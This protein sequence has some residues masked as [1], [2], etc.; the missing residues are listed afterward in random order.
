VVGG[1]HG[2][3]R[4]DD[5]GQLWRPR[6][7]AF[8]DGSHG[9][10]R[11][12]GGAVG[13]HR[14][15]A[16]RAHRGHESD[17]AA[18]RG[19]WHP[20]TAPQTFEW[21]PGSSHTL[22]VVSPQAGAA[23]TR[24]V[25]ASW[26]DG[27]AQSHT[28]TAGASPATYTASFTTQY[29]LTAVAE[30][31][32]GGTVS[33]AGE[34]WH[35]A[36]AS[37]SLSATAAS[38]YEFIDW[39]G[40]ASGSTNPVT[41]TMDASKSVTA[42][43]AAIVETVSVPTVPQ[44]PDSGT[45]GESYSYTTGG[46]SSNLGNP[47][48]YQFDWGDGRVSEWSVA[49]TASTAWTTAGNYG[50]RARARSATDLT[51]Q[52]EWSAA[53]TVV[54]EV[55]RVA[56]TVDTS[57]TGLQ[58]VVDGTPYTAPQTFDW[59]PGSSHT[60][61]VVSPQA[62]AAGTRQVFASWSDGGAQSHTV[63]AGASPATYTASFTT[64]YSLTAVAEPA[65]G[66]TVSPAGESWHDAGASVSLS[67]T[68][69]S[70]YE[71]IDWSGAAS[72]ST[73]PVTVTMDA[74]K[75]V[76]AHFAAIVETVSVPT[77]PQ[78]PDSGTPGESYSYTTGGSSSN[79]GNPVEYQFDWGDGRVSEWSVATTVSTAWTTAGNYGVRARARSATDLTVQSEWSA[80]RTVV[81]EV[82]RVAHTVDTSPTGLQIVV[83][84]TPY[85]APQTF[86]WTPGSSHTLAVV[87]PQ[88]GA[89]GTRQV[90]ASWSDGGAQSHTVTAGASPATYTASFTTQYSLTAVA[91]PATGGTVSPAGESW[92]DAGASVSLSAT[93]ASGYEF[94][95]WSGAASGSTNPVTVTMDGSK[96]VTAH[97]AA[98]PGVLAVSP[99]GSADFQGRAGGPFSPNRVT[100]TLANEGGTPVTWRVTSTARWLGI[101][102][103]SGTLSPGGT[104]TVALSM[105]NR[106]TRNLLPGIYTETVVFE[107][108]TDGSGSTT[109][110]VNLTITTRR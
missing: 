91:E 43:F 76:T 9:A 74:S 58:I 24:Q 61:A 97:F 62:G 41:V 63:T 96:S 45:P 66:G 22:A 84:G 42:H 52:S 50:V 82:A 46:S 18:D 29:S 101:S 2:E 19:R 67:A 104:V 109:R 68:A 27:G 26:S 40:A 4:L 21:T 80:A 23:G 53:R 103:T 107:N 71:F 13:G 106:E 100:Y 60:L 78:G 6:P 83:D 86:D 87:S 47:V 51:V 32:T 34:S 49:T 31:A 92:H 95:D 16:G 48:E 88:A 105:I 90:F 12:V 77:V 44:G 93:A 102:P 85:T 54:I 30:P 11:V 1:H 36:G 65:T 94:I 10:V 7:G 57:P 17:G 8:G 55:A 28:V 89:A 98:P 72:G 35:D 69:A 70:G 81:I 64:Q 14:G 39:S 75:S 37:V 38:G 59:A 33:P 5:G 108:L 20:Y 15:G 110:Q 3:H 25:F 56:H 73:N 79:L 99:G